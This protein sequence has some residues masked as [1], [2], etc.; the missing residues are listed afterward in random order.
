MRLI[1]EEIETNYQLTLKAAL[2]EIDILKGNGDKKIVY[3][4]HKFV[5]P[6]LDYIVQDFEK[7]RI[8]MNDNTIGAMVVCDSSEQA[9]MLYDIFQTKYAKKRTIEDI[10][11]AYLV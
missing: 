2:E 10:F 4:H 1:R 3:A 9:K 7:A 11:L 6:M 5:E 8:A